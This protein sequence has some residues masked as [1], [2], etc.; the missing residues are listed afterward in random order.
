VLLAATEQMDLIMHGL[1][2]ENSRFPVRMMC[3]SVAALA[4]CA[5]NQSNNLDELTSRSV[6]GV[7]FGYV[8]QEYGEPSLDRNGN[9]I[10]DVGGCTVTYTVRDNKIESFS[11]ELVDECEVNLD[12]FIV[13]QATTLGNVVE[14]IP[15]ADI[16]VEC[17]ECGNSA[18]PQVSVVDVGARYNG[19]VTAS[20]SVR[21]EDSSDI[22]ELWSQSAR[23]ASADLGG[24][25]TRKCSDLTTAQTITKTKNKKVHYVNIYVD[26]MQESHRIGGVFC[27]ELVD[28]AAKTL[29]PK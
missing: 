2:L 7:D 20:F 17:M 11:L 29:S 22:I 27:R 3:L 18:D 25:G 12:G 14:H 9:F 19:Y 8:K 13:S 4:L 5:C 16:G 6:I 1:S 15:N 26:E 10:Y 24:S 23:N 21:Y 28:G